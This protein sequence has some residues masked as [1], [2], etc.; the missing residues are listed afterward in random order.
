MEG[1]QTSIELNDQFT[2]IL[3]SVIASVNLAVFAMQDMQGVMNGDID[4]AALEGAR[5]EIDRATMAVN[6][7]EGAMSRVT[8]AGSRS[9]PEVQGDVPVQQTVPV[10][11]QADS[12]DVVT[13]SGMERFRQEA[14]RVNRMLEQL[15]G[16]QDSIAGQARTMD[17]LPPAA[18][19]DLNALAGR[20]SLI[21]ENIRRIESNPMNL[22]TE[23]VNAGLEHLRAQLDMA[24]SE[25]RD[26]NTAMEAM[27][28]SA[29]NE[30]YLRLSRTVS[31]TERYIRDNVDEQ[32]RFNQEIREGVSQA[33]DLTDTMK[34]AAAAYI[35]IQGAGRVLD[36]SDELV[37][38]TSRL[39]MMNDGVRST[40]ELVNMVYA[41]AQ[42][43]RGSFTGMA[44]VVARFGNN[45][46][47]AFGSSEEV[48]AFA[49]LVQKQMTIA[50]ASTQEA[51]SAQLQLSQALGS[52]VLRGDELNSIFEQAPN[53]IRNIADYLDVPIGQIR[54]MASEGQLSADVVKAA[55]FAASDEINAKFAGMPMT[56]SQAW[57]SMENT[58][59]IAFQPVLQRLND[60]AGSEAF[61]EFADTAVEA[62]AVLA[63]ITL[64]TFEL[65]GTGASLVAD[66]W[67]WLSPV[68]YGVGTALV[69]YYG[70]MLAYNTVTGISTAV[71]AAKTFAETAHAAS[72]AMS[73]GASFT[74]TAA[75]YGLNAA[76]AACPV[77]WI[78]LA[79]I[80][81]VAV[82]YAACAAVAH[83]T[84][85]ANSGFGVVM[86][87]ASVAVAFLRNLVTGLVNAGIIQVVNFYNLAANFAA[88]FGVLFDNPAAAIRAVILS[89][90]N[91]IV[92]VVGKA[93]AILD[94][95]FGS[96]LEAAVSGFQGKIQAEIDATIESAGGT[97]ATTLNPAD[98]MLERTDYGD[99]F[100]AGA[101]WGDGIAERIS[102]FRIS[103]LFGG[104]EI[105]DVGG[106]TSGF[107]DVF[108]SSGIGGGVSD[109]AGNTGGIRDSLD[110][111]QEDLKYL[112]DIAEQEA[113][114][115]YTLAEVKIEQT[116]H[117]N[118]SGGMDLDGIVSG[119]TDAVN[120]AVDGITEGV[121]G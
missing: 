21:R 83:F 8:S 116:N 52:G 108:D 82:I 48:V 94:A 13:G 93:A 57:Q 32:G 81:L 84:G 113:V 70:A 54:E 56:W 5:A 63:G 117:N 28:V 10:Q 39:D 95:V 98:Y 72:L 41:A 85:V 119:L 4:T 100:R 118:V 91:Y 107:A 20:I 45:A 36:I 7:L 18:S 86:G 79:V 97:A 31:G 38:T 58:A 19:Q 104:T 22:G 23:S 59:L 3:N 1:L 29:A 16:T 35:S 96:S 43:A 37:Q 110:C 50:G 64:D 62:M 65:M 11:W 80:A 25:Q 51:A 112:R 14:E 47:D 12:L 44:D 73:A 90:F 111:S 103:D 53:L 109:I 115:R 33:D 69:F 27:D 75:Q 9:V 106:Y 30:A 49:D 71:T 114:N 42:D 120:E 15:A 60:L 105:P 66:N 61:R 74:A 6:E 76:L 78:V 87:A 40:G 89:L 46:R 121:H 101:A 24:V 26:L 102:D 88:A 77:T 99:A 2:G 34:R 68:I 17:I 92:A 55:V 67:S